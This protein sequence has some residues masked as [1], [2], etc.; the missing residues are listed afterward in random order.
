MKRNR[1]A[2]Q[3][4]IRF[5]KL[6]F[7]ALPEMWTFHLL[8]G[9]IL[10]IPT[11][12]ITRLISAV[13][14]LGG[15]AL[16]SANISRLFLNWR[17]PIILVLAI[18]LVALYVAIELLAQI[19]M[20]ADILEGKPV[21]IF[22]EIGAGFRSVKSFFCLAGALILLYVFI[23][24]PICGV[25]FS[26]GLTSSFRIPNFIMDVIW[27][28][29]L[30]TVIYIAAIIF[31]VWFGYRSMFAFHAVLL[32]DMSP[33]E[34]KR[35]SRKIVKENWKELLGG[36]IKVV[37]I[38]T[39]ITTAA[40]ALFNILPITL[41]GLRGEELPIPYY[42]D[43]AQLAVFDE[44]DSAVVRY[45]IMCALFVL[46]GAYLVSVVNMLCG[47]YFMLR[48]TRWYLAF[49][50]REPEAWPER[51]K[52]SGYSRKIFLVVAILAGITVASVVIGL[53]YNQ[54]FGR[55]EP[56]RIVAHRAGGYLAPENSTEGVYAAIEHGCYASEIDVQRT[57]DGYYIICHDKNFKRLAGVAR[58]PKDMTLDEIRQLEVRDTT[59]SG[60]LLR[61]P[62]LS[63]MLE[64]AGKEVT[65]FIELK[66]TTADRQ[67]VD[68]VVELVREYDC[69]DDVA[70]ISLNYNLINYAETMYPE[71]TTGTLFYFGIGNVS[72]LN[73]DLLIMEEET[74]SD[75]VI[76]QIH[77]AGKEAI[78]WTVN[79]EASM[80]RFLDSRVDAVIT[81]EIEMAERVQESLDERTDLEVL[82]DRLGDFWDRF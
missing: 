4:N 11:T 22:R 45:R 47:G 35:L 78:V 80:R 12:L 74:A 57:A 52:E 70:L 51:P 58:A 17:F 42:I 32:D 48:F 41:L 33:S 7:E 9:L 64:A 5:L 61:V 53:C 44:L 31:L 40:S 55:E 13:A 79:K 15:G 29:P 82:Q 36:L 59:G 2:D 27:A 26:I 60:K 3:G 8:S 63:E 65:L 1:K 81:D 76:D 62:T 14:S 21:S 46:M 56:V 69:V 20:T 71:F 18:I 39:L 49:T 72:R 54:I 23:A 25:G 73:C 30:Y 24:V 68:D 37:I 77:L 75:L 43:P 66:G 10:V 50:G 38:I 67:M 6:A 34:G 16:T 19:H 28:T